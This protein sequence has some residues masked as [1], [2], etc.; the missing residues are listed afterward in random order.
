MTETS[1]RR[2]ERSRRLRMTPPSSHLVC[3]L[4]GNSTPRRYATNGVVPPVEWRTWSR[5]TTRDFG[6]GR[7][8]PRVGAPGQGQG[9]TATAR[10]NF[11]SPLLPGKVVGFRLAGIFGSRERSLGR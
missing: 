10:P 6:R 5:R 11:D 1:D 2:A 7:I 3:Q 9:P 4:V 8:P